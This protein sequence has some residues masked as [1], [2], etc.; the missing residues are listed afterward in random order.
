LISIVGFSRA[1]SVLFWKA[2]SV[3]QPDEAPTNVRPATLSYVAVGG[4]LSLLVAHTIFAGQV[5]GY[6]TKMAAQ[7]FEPQPYIATVID[8]PGKLSKPQKKD[9]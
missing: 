1:G 8:T 3:L 7:L 5:H 2:H 9:H 6:T 4:L